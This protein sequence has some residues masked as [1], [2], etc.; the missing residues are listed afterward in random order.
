MTLVSDYTFE[1][2]IKYDVT[3]VDDLI[4]NFEI[5]IKSL[6]LKI[7]YRKSMRQKA[8][9]FT[10]PIIRAGT[11]MHFSHP[12]VIY[13]KYMNSYDVRTRSYETELENLKDEKQRVL[14]NQSLR[15]KENFASVQ[16]TPFVFTPNV[17]NSSWYAAKS[18]LD[19]ETAKLNS[20]LLTWG[21][22]Q[23]LKKEKIPEKVTIV[24]D[25][26]IAIEKVIIVEDQ[27]ITFN[28]QVNSGD[29]NETPITDVNVYGGCSECDGIVEST[30]PIPE[31]QLNEGYMKMAGIAA[32]GIIG[33]MVLK[34]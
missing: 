18:I 13:E 22:N 9:A 11:K 26:I 2:L 5:E 32:L 17:I 33:L 3:K 21:N 30:D 7:Q 24:Q 19:S 27:Q 29:F 16:F 1:K 20:Q 6:Q 34:K 31:K 28:E 25:K 15:G 14:L 4:T 10:R 12:K 8:N 23:M